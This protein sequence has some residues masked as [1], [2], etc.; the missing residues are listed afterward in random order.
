MDTRRSKWQQ[1]K[2]VQKT[3][4]GISDAGGGQL[5]NVMM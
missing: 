4:I 1:G 2:I 3:T 5:V